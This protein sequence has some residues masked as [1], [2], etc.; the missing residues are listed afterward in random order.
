MPHRGVL[1]GYTL[2]QLTGSAGGFT[3]DLYTS[4]Q[5]SAPNNALPEE[6]FHLLSLTDTAEVTV[7]ADVVG[8][9]ENNNLSIAYQNRDGSPSNPQRFLYLRITPNGSG[10]KNFALSVTVETPTLR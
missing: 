9:A 4:S 5:G 6:I 7:D 3:A 2:A 1:R 8:L 10:N